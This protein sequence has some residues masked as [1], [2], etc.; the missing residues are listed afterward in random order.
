M[1]NAPGTSLV[2]T[3]APPD[4]GQQTLFDNVGYALALQLL[5]RA[6]HVDR[7]VRRYIECD[8]W[9]GGD[10][11]IGPKPMGTDEGSSVV[12]AELERAF[13]SYNAINEILERHVTSVI[14]DAPNWDF[15]VRRPLKGD[16]KLTPAEEGQIDEVGAALSTWWKD[17]KVHQK[18][19]LFTRDLLWAS[20]STLRL[21]IPQGYLVTEID[22][23]TGEQYML[24]KAATF[25]DALEMIFLDHP[26]PEDSTVFIDPAT[27]RWLGITAYQV[28]NSQWVTS[29]PKIIEMTY[30]DENDQTVIRRTSP[31]DSATV[32]F[33]LGG[34]L[35]MWESTRV[36]P[37]I[38]RPVVE[39]QRALNLALS[40]LPRNVVT[41]GFLERVLLNAQLPG[42]WI[43]NDKGERVG[44]KPSSYK[45]GAGTTNF[46]QG[47]EFI[48]VDGNTRLMTPDIKW[49]PP[50]DTAPTQ[51]A[52]DFHYVQI[53]REGK[54]VHILANAQAGDSGWSKEQ[55]RTDF[56][57]SLGLT[58]PEV[59]SAGAWLL[60]TVVAFAELLS[61]SPGLYTKE[62][63]AQF[64]CQLNLGPLS[65]EDRAQNVAE[66]NANLLSIETAMERN[67]I[68]DVAAEQAKIASQPNA[69][70]SLLTWQ[71][72]TLD[73]LVA[74]GFPIEIA[75]AAIDMDPKI[76]AQL[77]EYQA[78][79]P[80]PPPVDPNAPPPPD[81]Q[82]PQ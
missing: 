11:W 50:S 36:S 69:Q 74:A 44:F 79:N 21:Y 26:A 61:N 39:A 27:Q 41:G 76:V 18:L 40:M 57:T 16:G 54:Q 77:K 64:S 65:P 62:L 2:V 34:R 10:G 78:E 66:V 46:V 38:T 71:A 1:A 53:L 80:P 75:A 82:P 8:H 30:L 9:Q 59:E 28:F 42:T 6:Q 52:A 67:G 58:S 29:G 13:I 23:S 63:K 33:D 14:G 55:A 20:R 31:N 5:M 24:A 37:L 73:N 51:S 48:D 47:T 19:Q 3:G 15:T 22:A 35:T 43:L 4:E 49:R 45:T 12:M 70:Q 60:E 7:C 17:R 32:V 25:E 72:T 56:G 81:N 68:E